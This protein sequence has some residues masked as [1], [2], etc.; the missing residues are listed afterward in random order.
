[1]NRSFFVAM[2]WIG[3]LLSF[4]CQSSNHPWA[5]EVYKA[6]STRSNPPQSTYAPMPSILPSIDSESLEM[7]DLDRMDLDGTTPELNEVLLDPGPALDA[8]GGF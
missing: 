2:C 3:V 6:P 1:M 8:L 7:D 5:G 4:G